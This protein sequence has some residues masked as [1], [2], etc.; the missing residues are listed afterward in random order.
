MLITPKNNQVAWLDQ[1]L[2]WQV[3]DIKL[4]HQQELSNNL[5]IT[6]C[7]EW[8]YANLSI[9]IISTPNGSILNLPQKSQ[10]NGECSNLHEVKSKIHQSR[11]SSWAGLDV[12][13]DMQI[14]KPYFNLRHLQSNPFLRFKVKTNP[15][16]KEKCKSHP[17]I[18]YFQINERKQKVLFHHVF[19]N[20]FL[21][22][23]NK[24]Q[25]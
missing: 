19:W 5:P 4:N 22:V 18:F 24:K 25:F 12:R 3:K 16:D 14:L 2:T 17:S 11:Q 20:L 8:H 10:V 15:L 9:K 7:K 1:T 13:R 6:T 21:K 23:K